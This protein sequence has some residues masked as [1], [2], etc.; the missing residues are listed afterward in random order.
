MNGFWGEK[1]NVYVFMSIEVKW[2]EQSHFNQL[3]PT[4]VT[5]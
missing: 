3:S 5:I 4:K 2:G 1:K